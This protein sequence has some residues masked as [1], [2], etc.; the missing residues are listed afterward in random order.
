M[1]SSRTPANLSPNPLTAAVRA[2]R[3]GG[4]PF[5]D[6]TESNP[7]RV[8]FDYPPDFLAPLG[9]AHGLD[10]APSPLGAIEA[11]CAIAADYQRQGVPVAAERI[12]LTAST[13]DA[14]S[15]LFKLL[16]NADDEVLVPRPSY[17]LFDHLTRLDLLVSR[18]YDLDITATG[19]SIRQ[20]RGRD[21][22]AHARCPHR[23]PQQPDRILRIS[24]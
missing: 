16:A 2:A 21:H 12:V 5:I 9:D 7:T 20:P 19:R 4:R 1:F 6:L 8:G 3:A 14:Y 23:Q 11:R 24:G 22:T 15:L 17:P 10:Y 13:S 18:L